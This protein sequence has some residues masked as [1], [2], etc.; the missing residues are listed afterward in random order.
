MRTSTYLS[1]Y[2]P[3]YLPIYLSTY[4]P[5][6][7]SIY[8]STFP[9]FYISTFLPI[10]LPP[11]QPICLSAYLP[12]CLS[13]Y[14][15]IYLSAYLPIYLSIYLSTYPP[16]CLSVYLPICLSGYLSTWKHPRKSVGTRHHHPVWFLAASIRNAPPAEPRT[17]PVFRGSK[18]QI[19]KQ[20]TSHGPSNDCSFQFPGMAT[21]IGFHQ[22]PANHCGATQL[23]NAAVISKALA[24]LGEESIG[25]L[26]ESERR[27]LVIH[28]MIIIYHDLVQFPIGD[29]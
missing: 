14:L 12:I 26:P 16:I 8:L 10:Y 29:V 13:A 9:P 15:P 21:Q 24:T 20:Y 27:I 7:L 4:L 25:Q 11:Y 6:Y 22:W 17:S 5:I 1:I 23:I 18:N 28:G 19:I 3:A 2:L